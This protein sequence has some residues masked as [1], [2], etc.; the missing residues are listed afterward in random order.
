MTRNM[1]FVLVLLVSMPCLASESSFTGS[2][3]TTFGPMQLKQEGDQVTG[4]YSMQGVQCPVS[5]KVKEG[6]LEFTYQEGTTK[7]EGWFQLAGDGQSFAG[8]WRETG[9]IP[10]LNWKGT[11]SKT[12]TGFVGLWESEEAIAAARPRMLA[13]LDDVR[14]F[15]E[16]LSPDLGVTDPVSGPIIA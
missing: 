9:S 16:E 10:W 13:H 4:S 5:G 11:R 1:A 14:G 15:M 6:K 3:L 2:W 7:G 8:K 12:E